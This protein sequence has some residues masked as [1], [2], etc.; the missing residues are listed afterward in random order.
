MNS[1][2]ATATH[3]SNR[4]DGYVIEQAKNNLRR[5]LLALGAGF[6]GIFSILGLFISTSDAGFVALHDL[7]GYSE[8]G[9]SRVIG[10]V[11]KFF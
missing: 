5:K 3:S 6:F 4:D 10:R 11:G 7:Y 1:G 8:S 9:G 2:E